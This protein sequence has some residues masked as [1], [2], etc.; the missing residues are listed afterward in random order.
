MDDTQFNKLMSI[1]ENEYPDIYLKLI[2]YPRS[3]LEGTFIDL[4]T[5]KINISDN[6]QVQQFFKFRSALTPYL[7]NFV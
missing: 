4:L 5:S 3:V 7:D 6:E 1:F 2:N